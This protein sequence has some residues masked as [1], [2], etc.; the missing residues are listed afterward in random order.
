ML[1]ART[2]TIDQ[3]L[4][5]EMGAD[6]YVSKPVEP[7]LLLARCRAVLRRENKRQPEAL[8]A[9]PQC[10]QT[11]GIEID[12]RKRIVRVN[13][14]VIGLSNPEYDLL[15]LLVNNLG[16]IVSRDEISRQ[17]RGVEYDGQS[18]Q[19]DIHVSAIR[20]KLKSA[21]HDEELIKTV[22]SKGYIYVGS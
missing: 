12:A 14:E 18:R 16:K 11:S 7:R 22:R 17:L 4:G 13:G 8:T 6:D 5:L 20:N 19:I 15:V 3:V 9:D 21:S 10:I 1:T 2:D